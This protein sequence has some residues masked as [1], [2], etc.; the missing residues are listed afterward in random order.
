VSV[1]LTA[2]VSYQASPEPGLDGFLAIAHSRYNFNTNFLAQL[3]S[4]FTDI[5]ILNY[6][7]V[8]EPV[9][10]HDLNSL[11]YGYLIL[12]SEPNAT[13]TDGYMLA[14]TVN[15]DKQIE[16]NSFRRITKLDTSVLINPFI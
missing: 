5:S 16:A 2:F 12:S 13:T 3:S 7:F 15:V 1:P 14:G 10:E 4:L 8:F 11:Y 6:Q 9:N